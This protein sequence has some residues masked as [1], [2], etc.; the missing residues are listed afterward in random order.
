MQFLTAIKHFE[1][2]MFLL[3]LLAIADL[4]HPLSNNRSSIGMIGCSLSFALTF[5]VALMVQEQVQLNEGCLF[6]LNID[7]DWVETEVIAIG[8]RLMNRAL[9]E[10]DGEA[11]PT[12]DG[13]AGSRDTQPA[14]EFKEV[15]R[16]CFLRCSVL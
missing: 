9:P 10:G 7:A 6:R 2:K 14:E 12:E 15:R 5:V 13:D 16:V 4:I 11:A 1:I 8:C 3:F